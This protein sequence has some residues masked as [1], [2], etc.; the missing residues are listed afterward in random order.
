MLDMSGTHGSCRRTCRRRGQSRHTGSPNP[1]EHIWDVTTSY[2]RAP[3]RRRGRSRHTCCPP[4]P[5][6][7]PA[8][9]VFA[10]D[11]EAAR[12]EW[13]LPSTRERSLHGKHKCRYFQDCSRA[14]HAIAQ[15]VHRDLR[16]LAPARTTLQ[17]SCWIES[18]ITCCACIQFYNV[19]E[20]AVSERYLGK[21]AVFERLI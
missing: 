3:C 1:F 9:N 12:S 10:T 21:R 7:A 16:P 17:P 4:H 2:K 18:G 19:H 5:Q 8:Q 13:H 15:R 14:H 11:V 20:T 6:R